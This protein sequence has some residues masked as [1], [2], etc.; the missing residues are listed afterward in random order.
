MHAPND[1]H[2]RGLQGAR[3]VNLMYT[4]ISLVLMA[5]A[6]VHVYRYDSA[7][8][9]LQSTRPCLFSVHSRIV[10]VVT[11]DRPTGLRQLLHSKR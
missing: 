8:L 5:A 2:R 7:L 6:V 1:P 11:S 10:G 9:G 4:S 3:H